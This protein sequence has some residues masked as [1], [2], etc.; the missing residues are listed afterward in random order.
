MH[1]ANTRLNTGHQGR[2]WKPKGVSAGGAEVMTYTCGRT[3]V[4][5]CTHPA[6]SHWEGYTTWAAVRANIDRTILAPLIDT[7]M[8]YTAVQGHWSPVSTVGLKNV[9]W[10]FLIAPC[11]LALPTLNLSL[12]PGEWD[13]RTVSYKEAQDAALLCLDRVAMDPSSQTAGIHFLLDYKD[14]TMANLFA[15]NIMA[16]RRCLNYFQVRMA[17]LCVS[18]SLYADEHETF[19]QEWKL[20]KEWAVLVVLISEVFYVSVLKKLLEPK[21]MILNSVLGRSREHQASFFEILYPFRTWELMSFSANTLLS[22]YFHYR[23][24]VLHA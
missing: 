5:Q 3:G 22:T 17:K 6:R 9:R 8:C 18:F 16:M 1:K 24:V 21:L 11:T 2:N 20:R 14:F 13:P 19:D 15:C 4:H 10:F 23:Y 12:D 7:R